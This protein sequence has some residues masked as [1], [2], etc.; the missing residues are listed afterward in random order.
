MPRKEEYHQLKYYCPKCE[1][2]HL[3]KGL[4]KHP[5]PKQVWRWIQDI[6]ICK[7]CNYSFPKK[8]FKQN[9]T[10]YNRKT[11]EQSNKNGRAV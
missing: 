1:T 3:I 4:G 11:N 2:E 10:K 8:Q 6:F 9:Y 5:T 7:E